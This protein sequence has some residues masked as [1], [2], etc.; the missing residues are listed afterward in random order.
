MIEQVETLSALLN[1]P[2]NTRTGLRNKTML[3]IL[4]DTAIRAEE[5]ITLDY[6]DINLSVSYPYIHVH[7]NGN[8]DRKI[9]FSKGTIE[10]EK[11]YIKEFHSQNDRKMPF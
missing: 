10:M 11:Q 9:Y 2:P 5:L 4:F 6:S 1:A 3:I 7:G 8:K